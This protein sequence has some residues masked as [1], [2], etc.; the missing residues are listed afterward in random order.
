MSDAP[1]ASETRPAQYILYLDDTGTR[2]L[3]K[4]AA[5]AN[6]HPQWFSLGGLLIAQQDEE[7]VKAEYDALFQAW[8]AMTPPLHITDM[9]A[10]RKGFTWLEKLPPQE[11]ARFWTSY[12]DFLGRLPV[13][14]TACVIHRPGYLARGYGSRSGD[15]KWNLCRTAFN[16]VVERAA[17][18]VAQRG[19]RLRVKYEGSDPKADQFIKGYWAL[20]KNGNGLQFDQQ[21]SAKYQP[22]DPQALAAVLIDLERKDKRSKLMQ[23]ADTYVYALA[24]GRYEPNFHLHEALRRHGRVIDDQ[25]DPSDAMILGVKYS[26][27]D[28]L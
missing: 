12:C 8:P 21:N 23:I 22:I 5:T 1:P 28:G 24:R 13:A 6:Q 9:Q 25:V 15:A 4:L 3:D 17:K 18:V 19:G 16:I 27:F 26:C 14:A 10:R 20:L 7:A 2:H 11:Q